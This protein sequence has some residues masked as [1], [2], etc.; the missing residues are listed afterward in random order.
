MLVSLID[1]SHG[2]RS[3]EN[4][5]PWNPHNNDRTLAHYAN[6]LVHFTIGV[7]NLLDHP[8]H[9]YLIG[10]LLKILLMQGV[11]LPSSLNMTLGIYLHFTTSSS[12]FYI[13]V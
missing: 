10:V 7:L 12:P 11:S 2:L 13:R 9:D 5:K 1:I 3:L 6:I 8:D 4:D